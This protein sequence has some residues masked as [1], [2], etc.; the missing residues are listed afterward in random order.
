MAVCSGCSGSGKCSKCG[1]G[2]T[3]GSGFGKCS[4]CGGSQATALL[5][6][7]EEVSSFVPMNMAVTYADKKIIFI[8]AVAAI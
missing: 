2:G 1:G 5:V 3:G 7:A 4:K 6:E 8:I